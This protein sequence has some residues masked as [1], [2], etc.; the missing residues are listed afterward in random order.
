[1]AHRKNPDPRQYVKSQ[2]TYGSNQKAVTLLYL[3]KWMS[4]CCLARNP[5]KRKHEAC[6]SAKEAAPTPPDAATFAISSAEHSEHIKHSEHSNASLCPPPAKRRRLSSNV[7]EKSENSDTLEK[8]TDFV[9]LLHMMLDKAK[10]LGLVRYQGR[11]YAPSPL[12]VHVVDGK[13]FYK[14][15][16]GTGDIRDFVANGNGSHPNVDEILCKRLL[17]IR[18]QRLPELLT[19]PTKAPDKLKRR[20]RPTD[21]QFLVQSYQYERRRRKRRASSNGCPKNPPPTH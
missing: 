7:S 13:G 16:N 20:T 19:Q 5:K 11:I 21:E 12:P 1:M 6:T 9:K 14:E 8:Q 4:C 18:D 15:F 3:G 2:M 10:A 17:R